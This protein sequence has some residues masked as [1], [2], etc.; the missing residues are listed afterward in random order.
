MK[1][2]NN[3]DIFLYSKKYTEKRYKEIN[4]TLHKIRKKVNNLIFE[5]DYNLDNKEVIRLKSA[6]SN[7]LSFKSYI[8]S[9]SYFNPT[10]IKDN[11]YFM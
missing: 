8:D 1:H 10:Q 2:K 3:N 6:Y 5:H 7:I 4:K 11:N 9:K